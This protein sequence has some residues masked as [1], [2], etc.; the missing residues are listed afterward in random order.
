MVWQI[1][2]YKPSLKFGDCHASEFL[3]KTVLLI[4]VVFIG[5]WKESY[6][7]VPLTE[8]VPG[9]EDGSFQGLMETKLLLWPAISWRDKN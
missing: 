7:L 2:S 3:H 6:S 1:F 8:L 5:K 9:Y 4:W